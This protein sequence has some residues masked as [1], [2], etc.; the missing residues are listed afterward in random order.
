MADDRSAAL[1]QICREFQVAILYAFGSR[2]E[3]VRDW[4]QG[5]RSELTAGPSDVDIGV[6]AMPG[7]KWTLDDKIYM[8]MTLEDFFNCGRVD[9]VA[10][11]AANAFLAEEIIRGERL[12][13]QD[14]QQA[15]EY[16]L[17]VL[18]R[19]GDLAPLEREWM[20]QVLERKAF[21]DA[22]RRSLEQHPAQ[23]EPR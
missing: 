14:E 20:A 13:V 6:K 16:D 23:V 21:G 18:R 5:L 11:D 22:Y 15:D 10:L 17:Y 19:A 4:V 9:L 3:E 8:T 2:A 7:I 12:Y 1:A